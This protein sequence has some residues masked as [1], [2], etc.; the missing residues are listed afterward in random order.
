MARRD[1]IVVGASAGGLKAMQDLLRSLPNDLDAAILIAIH[2]QRIQGK[3][4]LPEIVERHS[5][6]MAIS[7]VHGQ[8][9]SPQRIYIAPPEGHL[10][11][12]SGILEV[13]TGPDTSTGKSIDAL[14]TSAANAYG[15]RVIGI[16]LSGTSAQS[17][18]HDDD[19]RSFCRSELSMV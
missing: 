14:F 8:M 7:V 17:H 12:Q 11:I 10:R 5:G 4:L 19:F 2:R 15:D 6:M 16:L 3:D 18:I 13:V 1:I 9:I